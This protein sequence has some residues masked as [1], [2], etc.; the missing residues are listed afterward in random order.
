MPLTRAVVT[1]QMDSN[2]PEDV[3]QNVLHINP[4]GA[5]ITSAEMDAAAAQISGFYQAVGP[6]LSANIQGVGAVHSIKFYD[7]NEGGFGP[8]DDQINSPIGERTFSITTLS[9]TASPPELAVCISLH[10]DLTNAYEE[11][12]ATR[13]ASRRRGRMYLGPLASAVFSSS[14]GLI[15][16]THQTD[17]AD[18][19]WALVNNLAGNGTP[20]QIYSRAEGA[21]YEVVGLWV[22]NAPDVQR[23]R[24]VAATS[25]VVRPV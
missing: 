14:T 13:P 15:S 20:L 18:S 21:F 23:R 4:V 17:I 7:V 25:R 2:L 16:S 8:G 11:W 24:G 1:L 22:D 9:S 19:A 3:V 12:G 10:A 6:K 5:P